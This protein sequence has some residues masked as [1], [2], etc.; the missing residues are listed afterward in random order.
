MFVNSTLES[1]KAQFQLAPPVDLP[2]FSIDF[3]LGV[4]HVEKLQ[5]K[6][7]TEGPNGEHFIVLDERSKAL[8]FSWPLFEKRVRL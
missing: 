4:E 2:D 6:A 1:S 8:K 3:N 7:V 5:N